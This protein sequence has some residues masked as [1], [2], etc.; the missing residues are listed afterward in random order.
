MITNPKI[1]TGDAEYSKL[2][3]VLRFTVAANSAAIQMVEDICGRTDMS[4]EEVAAEMSKLLEMA[5]H[6]NYHRGGMRRKYD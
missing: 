4:I 6:T 5:I 1:E 3:H 2:S